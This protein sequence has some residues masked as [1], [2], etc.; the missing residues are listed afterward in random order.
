VGVVTRR[1][2]L[3]LWLAWSGRYAE[4]IAIG[5]PYAAQTAAVASARDGY[6]DALHGLAMSY[7]AAGC[8]EQ[9][10][11]TFARARD[12]YRGL[13]HRV[14]VAVT[15]VDELRDVSLPFRADR[16]EERRQLVAEIEQIWGQASGA[17]P[18]D[19]W[20][21]LRTL[22]ACL[23][24]G[25]WQEARKL[26]LAVEEQDSMTAYWLT[27][28]V[29]GRIAREQG[30]AD[31]AWAVVHAG[32]PRGPASDPGDGIFL[33]DVAR[34]RLAVDLALDAG[35]LPLARAWIEAHA[36]WIAWSGDVRGQAESHLHWARY[37]QV[38]S[39]PAAA[40]RHTRQA[41]TDASQPRQPLAL[42]V[43]H[44]LHGVLDT[45]AARHEDAEHHLA[46]ALALADACAAPFEQALTLLA[47]AELRAATGAVEEARTFAQQARDICAALGA[48]P[49][50]ARIDAFTPTLAQCP[51]AAY[52]AG[53]TAREVEVLRL[54]AQGLT[55][56]EVAERLFLARRTINTH[57]T[58]IYTK[59]RVS[60]RA[61]ATRF[62]VEHGLT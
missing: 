51:A 5:E 35:D 49:T 10:R 11:E 8:P 43:A 31:L 27:G 54:V 55:D 52:P 23:L 48:T 39:D 1:G 21:R 18:L 19:E 58:S 45:A 38:A 47:R 46:S 24:D 13:D 30:D 50:I 28:P 25:A 44:R 9:A 34:Q 33:S 56:A 57:L 14:L 61:A 32:L 6:S 59:L 36:R 4:A 40:L 20:P 60:S 12:A 2:T 3:I 41:L 53:L 7:A 29:L 37:Q 16:A 42:L 17:T 15:G 62:A 22:A 26:A